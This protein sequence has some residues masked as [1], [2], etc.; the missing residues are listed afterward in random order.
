[1]A[2]ELDYAHALEPADA[3]VR[4][5]AL[6]EYLTNKHG[7]TVTWTSEDR[8][9]ISGKYMIVTIEGTLSIE[10]GKATFSGKDPGMLWRGKAK[11]YLRHKLRKYLDPA[12][13]PAALP[14]R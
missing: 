8:A 11:E 12:V 14:R 4:L 2:F 7:L 1:M 10:Q 5:H 3:R 6:G 13:E 9:Q